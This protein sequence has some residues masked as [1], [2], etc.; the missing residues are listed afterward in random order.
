[1]SS[2]SRTSKNTEPTGPVCNPAVNNLSTYTSLEEFEDSERKNT[3]N[4]VESYYVPTLPENQYSF[5]SV[6]KRDGVYVAV[7]Y[8]VDLPEEMEKVLRSDYD[9]ERCQTLICH[10]H[11]TEAGNAALQGYLNNGFHEIKENGNTYYR[12]DEHAENNTHLP[13]IGYEIVFL[14]ERKLIFMHLPGVGSF[15]EMMRY[16]DPEKRIIV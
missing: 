12:W 9:R 1:M 10:T 3:V 4:K 6:T 5:S 16:A 15:E 7:T 8:H 13:I 11:L 14:K 2:C